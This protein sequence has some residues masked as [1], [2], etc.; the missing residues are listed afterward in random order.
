MANINIFNGFLKAFIRAEAEFENDNIPELM[1]GEFIFA[2]SNDSSTNLAAVDKIC[3]KMGFIRPSNRRAISPI[4]RN[5]FQLR[6]PKQLL[7]WARSKR[8]HSDDLY[9][10]SRYPDISKKLK[11]IPVDVYWGKGAESQDNLMKK[12]FS[13]SWEGTSIIKRYLRLLI[14]GRQ[15][16]VRFLNALEMEDIFED[17]ESP[18]KILLKTERLLRGRFRKNKQA[19]LGLDVSH[20]RNWIKTLV[21]S[22]EINKY[23]ESEAGSNKRKAML[24]NRRAIKY[25]EEICSDV[26]YTVVGSLY[27]AA[28]SW[29]W[30]NRY[31]ELKFIGLEKVKN[32]AVDNSLIFTP[33]HRSHVDYLALS[34]ILYKNDL[35]LPQIAAGINLNLPIL[36]RILRNGGAFFMRRSFS[37]NRLYSIVFFEHLKKL[38]IRGNSIEFFPE[39]ARSR[40]GKLLPPRPGLLSMLIRSFKS[41]TEKPVKF[42]PVSINYEKVLEGN[43][44]LSELMGG[45]K[46]KER[47]SDIF[48]VASDFRGFLGNAYLQFGD[49]IDLKD[50][51]DA[52]NPG[53]ENNDSQTDGSS[54]DD[55][56]WL[57]NATPKLGEKI[58]MNINESTVVTSSSL[59]AAA[60]L[61]SNNHSLPKDKLESRID[62]YISLMNSSRYSNKTILPNQSSKKLL[63]QVNA[64]KL[65]PK[66]EDGEKSL[67]KLDKA[68]GA[69]MSFYRNTI[70][71]LLALESFICGIFQAREEVSKNEIIEI[72]EMLYPYLKGELFLK[73]NN[74]ELKL[75]I[76]KR[77]DALVALKLLSND[78]DLYK[79]PSFDSPH[80]LETKSLGRMIQPTIDRFYILMLQLWKNQSEHISKNQL[81]KSCKEIATNLQAKYDWMAPEFSDRW[82]FMQFLSKLI[83]QRFVKEDE[84]GLI[85]ASRITKKMQVAASKFIMPDW[86][87]ELNQT[88]YYS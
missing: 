7:P 12:L 6:E 41:R 85:Y 66:L 16:K 84:H 64:L 20:R 13:E 27:D 73:W 69:M 19:I 26:S 29:F 8:K 52:Q 36:G 28:L 78:R 83:E 87:E 23:I 60:L 65:I 80:Y 56:A 45:K 5:Y 49:P 15:V 33:C 22:K 40:S 61:N 62:L 77:L 14:N 2:L 17:R 68:Q 88:S 50:F 10:I 58:M 30:N 42:I 31:E 53:W 75:E 1:K 76:D 70:L 25:A 35:M 67:V 72:I 18:E 82:T 34:Y 43:S 3:K 54:S 59:V 39:G 81:E 86:R 79:R 47:I 46:R 71:H 24:L 57:F 9:E 38:L 32:L 51:L 4:K 37:E 63:E 48:R 21:N 74:E 55:N 44:Y 11:I